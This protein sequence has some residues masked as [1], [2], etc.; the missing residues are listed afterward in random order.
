MKIRT[1]IAA[2]ALVLVLFGLFFTRIQ[3][4]MADFAVNSKAGT[5]LSWGESLYRAEDGHYQFKYSP[6][7]ALIYVP[8]AAL[9]LP[10]AKVV[11]FGLILAASA[12]CFLF[13]LRLAR[14]KTNPP[15]WLSWLPLLILGR[16]FLR[17]LQLGQINALITFLL[18]SMT[19]LLAATESKDAPRAETGAGILWGFSVALKPYALIFLPY[20]II[21]KKSR[22]LIAG[23][24]SLALAFLMPALFYGLRGDWTVH[25]EWI[26]SLSRSTPRL[27]TSQDN[28]SLLA[29]FTK[30]TGRPDLAFRL[31]V[32]SLLLLIVLMFI[33][34]RK[35]R[36]IENPTALEC[37]LLLL[38]IPLVSPLGW[39]Y[40]FLSSVLVVTLICRRFIEYGRGG[41]L[42]LASVF[43]II[44][45]SLYDILGR[46]LYA[47][48]MSLSIITLCFLILSAYAAVLRQKR[49][50]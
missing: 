15:A 48:F 23:S 44:P 34:V 31:W 47:R 27:L 13:S 21:K 5:R 4:Q 41:R 17:E 22:A 26:Q 38:L 24:A 10:I 1:K 39:D 43:L 29:M 33:V 37:G 12:A 2:A 20:F 42:I 50:G 16:Y 40:T 28:V 19:S 36:K 8:L 11:W 9:P 25:R 49:L 35:G 30:W 6:F 3:K 45:L 7:A 14:D 32:P 46:R 18:L